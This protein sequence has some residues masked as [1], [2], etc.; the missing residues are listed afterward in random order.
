MPVD[1]VSLVPTCF[2]MCLLIDLARL[3]LA[4]DL[5]V[6]LC[7]LLCS[8]QLQS[9]EYACM[10]GCGGVNKHICTAAELVTNYY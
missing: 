5:A 2:S 7:H 4:Y 9:F 10:I 6:F 3:R 8:K 1:W